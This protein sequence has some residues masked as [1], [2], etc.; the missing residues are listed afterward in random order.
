LPDNV[1]EEVKVRRLNEIIA[2][3]N[4]LSNQSN[5]RDIGKT[6]EVLVEGFSKRSKEQLFGRTSQ[7]KVVIF[8]RLGR[9]IGETIKVKIESASSATLLG[10][11]VED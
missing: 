6:F 5:Q 1:D 2:L 4:E 8:P 9:R 7:N 3:Q 11:V 10:V